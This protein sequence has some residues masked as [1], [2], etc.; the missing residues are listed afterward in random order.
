MESEMHFIFA[1]DSTGGEIV[2]G[3]GAGAGMR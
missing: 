2:T 1:R 3:A